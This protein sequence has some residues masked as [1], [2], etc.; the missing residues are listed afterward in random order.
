MTMPV[1]RRVLTIAVMFCG[2]AVWGPP[3]LAAGDMDRA[4]AA[5]KRRDYR[6]A[7]RILDGLARKGN[8]EAQFKLG[9]LYLR[10][11]GV[12]QNFKRAAGWFQRGAARGHVRSMVNLGSLYAGGR[13]VPKNNALAARWFRRAAVKGDPLAMVK[14]GTMYANG[15][16]VRRNDVRAYVWFGLAAAKGL[17]LGKR[18]QAQVGGRMSAAQR[19]RAERL[20]KKRQA[21]AQD[22]KTL[23]GLIKGR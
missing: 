18:L 21:D 19:A 15:E 12:K 20:I 8:V 17:S 4:T 11:M 22:R 1:S 23:R 2:L 5:L 14:L 10:G 3:V 13:G 9:V 6:A 16:G 7:A